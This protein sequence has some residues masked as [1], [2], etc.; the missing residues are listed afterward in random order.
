MTASEFYWRDE[1]RGFELVG[2]L[3]E[4]RTNPKRITK[5][6]IVRLGGKYIGR[7]CRRRKY[8]VYSNQGEQR[9]GRDLKIPSALIKV[10][11]KDLDSG[12]CPFFPLAFSIEP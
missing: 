10:P 3:P 12:L 5:E 4:R 11:Q 8:P 2:V 6:S 1:I 9:N 7:T